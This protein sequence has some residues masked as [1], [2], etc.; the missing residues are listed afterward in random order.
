MKK[1]WIMGQ[2]QKEELLWVGAMIWVSVGGISEVREQGTG[3]GNGV[4]EG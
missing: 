2:M 1:Q 3:L 4:C